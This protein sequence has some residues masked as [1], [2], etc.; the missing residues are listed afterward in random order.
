MLPS[1]LMSYPPNLINLLPLDQE[2]DELM[3]VKREDMRVARQRAAT[4]WPSC[5]CCEHCRSHASS[6]LPELTMQLMFKPTLLAAA[7]VPA[8]LNRQQS[9]L[10]S[11]EQA[12]RHYLYCNIESSKSSYHILYI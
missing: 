9:C 8:P 5:A 7:A 10:L 2:R 12:V 3:S 1:A 11:A 4:S 6:G